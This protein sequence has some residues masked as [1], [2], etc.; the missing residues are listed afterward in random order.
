[1]WCRYACIISCSDCTVVVGAVA[2]MLRVERCE[3]LTLI[4]ASVRVC[5]GSCHE[6]T[7]YLGVNRP[8]LL[9]GDNRFLQVVCLVQIDSTCLPANS[10]HIVPLTSKRLCLEQCA[11]V[12]A[13]AM[14]SLAHQKTMLFDTGNARAKTLHA[15]FEIMEWG[16]LWQI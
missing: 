12:C 6:C 1:M 3:R 2:R 9:I 10:L 16:M 4:A 7:F 15:A 11:T 13:A 5:I 8:P 14:L